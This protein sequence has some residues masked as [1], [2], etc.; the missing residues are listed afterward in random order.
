MSTMNISEIKARKRK[1]RDT[2][3]YTFHVDGKRYRKSGFKTKTDALRKAHAHVNEVTNEHTLNTEITFKEYYNDW[4]IA[5]G[6]D[7][8][9]KK[10]YEWYERSLRYFL[11][12]YGEDK[13]LKNITKSEYQLFLN[14][15]GDGR[16]WKTVSKVH[17]CLS[18]V[19]KDAVYEGYLKI[20]PT[21]KTNVNGTKAPQKEQD[22]YLNEDEYLKLMEYF[23][24][25]SEKS[26]VLLFLLAITGARFSEVNNMTYK[27][28]NYSLGNVHLPGTK[29]ETSDRIVEVNPK[30]IEH[31]NDMLSKHPR[32]ID[33]K[34]FDISNQAALKTFKKALRDLNIEKD[35]TVYSLRHTHCSYLL[36][37]DIPIEYISKRLG[38]ASIN[39]T[40]SVYSHLLDEHKEKQG[41]KIRKLFS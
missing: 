35:R 5:N 13:L 4:V 14:K 29:T 12:E 16:T 37:K 19:L 11:E 26:Y 21:Y 41:K 23:R 18:Q 31:V 17:N 22:K 30:D 1:D 9:S 2:W 34:L 6:K 20:D 32:R 36:S 15:Y 28:L 10:Q 39:M 3:E 40:L 24:S 38:H 25:R 8:L 27:D 7:R 33:G